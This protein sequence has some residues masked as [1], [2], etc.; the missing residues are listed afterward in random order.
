[1]RSTGREQGM[2]SSVIGAVTTWGMLHF[3]RVQ[4]SARLAGGHEPW[5]A[6]P[7][8]SAVR[9][10]GQVIAMGRAR[11]GTVRRPRCVGC[12]GPMFRQR[13]VHPRFSP[14]AGTVAALRYPTCSPR[15]RSRFPQPSNMGD[16]DAVLH[17]GSCAALS[18]LEWMHLMAAWA[19][20]VGS[21]ARAASHRPCPQ[22]EWRAG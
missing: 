21:I 15:S 18:G 8:R 9:D 6:P 11:R 4:R 2:E 16:G 7:L 12:A 22:M 3:I 10:F 20:I 1:M 14:L 17:W 19:I 5:C 13:V